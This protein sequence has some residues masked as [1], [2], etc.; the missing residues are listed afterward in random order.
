MIWER[1]VLPL[2]WYKNSGKEV[3][4]S[5]IIIAAGEGEVKGM[6]V[7]AGTEVEI[8]PVPKYTRGAGDH[9]TTRRRKRIKNT[10]RRLHMHKPGNGRPR[11]RKHGSPS[12][13]EWLISIAEDEA[14]KKLW[15]LAQMHADWEV[16]QI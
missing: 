8:P 1:V 10:F 11:V 7:E 13:K 6:E 2:F 12:M 14:D 5:E 16:T 3:A 9:D 4:L 15:P